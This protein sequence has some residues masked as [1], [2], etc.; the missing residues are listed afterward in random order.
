MSRTYPEVR[1]L[2]EVDTLAHRV[3][4]APP[5]DRHHDPA[6][7]RTRSATTSTARSARYLRQRYVP[8]IMGFNPMMQFIHEED[9]AEAV[10]LALQTRHARRLQ[11]GRARAPCRCQVAIRET[12]GTALPIPEPLARAG[13]RPALPLGSTTRRR[14]RSTSSSTP[15]RSTAAAS[16]GHGLRAAL[17]ARGHLRQCPSLSRSDRSRDGRRPLR[18]RDARPCREPVAE[19]RARDRRAAAPHPDAAQRLRLRRLGASTR[20]TREARAPRHLA[21]LPLLVPR[22]DARH[23][24]RAG[25]TRAADRATT[26]ARSRSTPP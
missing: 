2:A 11:R 21:L 1:D 14:A 9:V 4:L 23:R 17:H 19:L 13:L 16:R 5:R 7:G 10:A 8:T 24:A 12:G 22:R 3:P 15:A 25:G 18:R 26:P 6:P 20:D